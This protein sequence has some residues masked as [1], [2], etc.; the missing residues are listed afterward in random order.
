MVKPIRVGFIGLSSKPSPAFA[1]VW[2]QKAHLPY[3]VNSEDYTIIAFCNSSTE[4]AK[5]AIQLHG[6]DGSKVRAYGDPRD[7]ASDADVD[8]IVCSVNVMQ[9]YDLI[10]P[11]L[12]AGK[13]AYCE[14]PL[15]SNLKQMKELAEM[16]EQKKLKTILGLQGRNGSYVRVIQEFVG[17]KEGQLGQV[18]S[19][20]MSTYAFFNGLAN[21]NE[22][23]Y[24][25]D[26]ESGA[27]MFT[28]TAIHCQ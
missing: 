27:N 11:A 14:W 12:L 2:G 19:T 15:G 7:L 24:L 6:L 9:H 22:V 3:L 23:A 8:M 13:M 16:A 1:G 5:K 10:K 28:V 4:S 20:E 17:N 26:I 25:M 18:L 21:P